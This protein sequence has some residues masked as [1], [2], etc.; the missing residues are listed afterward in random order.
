MARSLLK[1]HLDDEI[2]VH[3]PSGVKTY[4][5]IDIRYEAG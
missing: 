2:E 3:A 4:W 5:I 1:R